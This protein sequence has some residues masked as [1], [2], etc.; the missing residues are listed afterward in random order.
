[1][2]FIDEC[3]RAQS[4][5]LHEAM[6]GLLPDAL[7]IGFTGTPLLKKDKSNSQYTFGTYIHTYKFDQAVVDGV[8]L[9]LCYEA[10][11]IEQYTRSQDKI[12]AWFNAKTQGINHACQSENQTAMGEHGKVAFQQTKIR[13]NCL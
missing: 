13:K 10:R 9:D 6:K 3:H 4:G 11:D 1:M 7:F 8:V 5:L 12:D 2:V